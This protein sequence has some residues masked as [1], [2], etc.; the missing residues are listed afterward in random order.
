MLDADNRVPL[1]AEQIKERYE[2]LYIPYMQ[3]GCGLIKEKERPS[4]SP[5]NDVRNKFKTLRLA[6]GKIA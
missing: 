4:P 6:T 1:R 2:A 3:A 5:F